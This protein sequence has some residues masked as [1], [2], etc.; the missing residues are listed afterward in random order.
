MTPYE[1]GLYGGT[2]AVREEDGLRRELE[3]ATAVSSTIEHA[4]SAAPG[5]R[6]TTFLLPERQRLQDGT[7]HSPKSACVR[8]QRAETVRD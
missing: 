7:R 3:E 1:G 8:L 6:S 5:L 2:R 4:S